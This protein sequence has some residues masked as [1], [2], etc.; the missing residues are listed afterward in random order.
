MNAPFEGQ[1]PG[2]A[3]LL[4]NHQQPC[5]GCG[6][7][8]HFKLGRSPVPILPSGREL[9]DFIT[10]VFPDGCWIAWVWST[11]DP[12]KLELLTV[13][14]QSCL[15]DWFERRQAPES[16]PLSSEAP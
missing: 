2:T 4:L 16:I 15:V 6:V 11:T 1:E 5:G 12:R 9:P 7:P 14:G 8:V 10:P 3:P 13:C